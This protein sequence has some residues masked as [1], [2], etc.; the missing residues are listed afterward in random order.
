MSA[1]TW[2]LGVLAVV[3]ISAGEPG[4]AQTINGRVLDDQNDRPVA[5]ALVLL[6]DEDGD[7]RGVSVADSTG[8]YRIEAP[9]P[10][11]YRLRAE[12]LGYDEFETPLLDLREPVGIYPVDLLVTRS[13][14]AIPGFEI[15]TERSDRQVQLMIGLHPRSLRVQPIQY[16]TIQDHVVRAHDLT[17]M[18]R[19][20]NT[21]GIIVHE[22]RDGPCYQA[23]GRGCLPVFLNGF[24]LSPEFISIVP[25]D[26]LYTVVVL[27]PNESIAYPAGA[28]LLYT[29]AWLR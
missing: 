4:H 24:H 16:E 27:Y 12:R 13:P 2:S 14:I 15:T 26:M 29:A 9:E 20:Q 25:L 5:A 28:V 23:R 19:W 3:S 17:A 22:T 21:A 18:M 11:V 7:Q 1:S 8:F 6:V 10:G